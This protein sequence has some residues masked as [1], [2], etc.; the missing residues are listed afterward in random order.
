MWQ[1]I[2]TA[3]GSQRTTFFL[4]FLFCAFMG[5]FSCLTFRWRNWEAICAWVKRRSPGCPNELCSL[6]AKPRCGFR[7][8]K[9][10][11]NKVGWPRT[12]VPRMRL[13]E[14][15]GSCFQLGA[16]PPSGVPKAWTQSRG[17]EMR[18]A[19]A[20]RCLFSPSGLCWKGP[21]CMMGCKPLVV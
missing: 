15:A 19:E 20:F 7:V 4:P 5:I 17:W 11:Q 10:C 3:I 14:L 21:S 6:L 13:H 18:V 12:S 16:S 8:Y 1:L 9:T 2:L